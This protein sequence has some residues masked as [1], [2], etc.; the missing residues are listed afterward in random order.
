MSE[1]SKAFTTFTVRSLSIVLALIVMLLANLSHAKQV[2]ITEKAVLISS[3]SLATGSRYSPFIDKKLPNGGWSASVIKAVFKQLNIVISIDELPWSRALNSTKANIHY[4][5]FP[6]VETKDRNN[7]F[8]Y[9]EPINYVPIEIIANEKVTA[10]TVEELQKY[11]FC[12]PYG[13]SSASDFFTILSPQN[14]THAPTTRDC[15][16][17]ANNGWADIVLVNQYN[18]VLHENRYTHLKV[19]PISV[20]H[21]PLFFIVAKSHP[22]GKNLITLF[23]Q[24]LKTIK[25]NNVLNEINKQYEALLNNL[26]SG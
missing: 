18:Q 4:G 15:L 2:Q 12:L 16:N 19:L 14:I 7:D 11:S 1:F 23:N 10:T 17:K 22:Q 21:E 25:E 24:G 9:S 5:A 20:Q 3:V 8:Y 26:S 6:F 13:Y